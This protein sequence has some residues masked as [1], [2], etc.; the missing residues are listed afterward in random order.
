M[1]FTR[2][3]VVQNPERNKTQQTTPKIYYRRG[4]DAVVRSEILHVPN[5]HTA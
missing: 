2:L 5:P 1:C 3:E 4:I